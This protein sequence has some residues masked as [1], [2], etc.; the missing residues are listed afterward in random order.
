MY[1]W[2]RA[3]ARLV[4]QPR[5][6][7]DLVL[8]L[9][10]HHVSGDSGAVHEWIGMNSRLSNIAVAHVADIAGDWDADRQ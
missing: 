3:N 6:G 9:G 8:V 4:S 10:Q 5:D 2:P 1:S 7:T